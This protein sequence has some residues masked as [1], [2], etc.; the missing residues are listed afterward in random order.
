ML[1]GRRRVLASPS[2]QNYCRHVR[3][4]SQFK[5]DTAWVKVLEF[6]LGMEVT[7]TSKRPF[8]FAKKRRPTWHRGSTEP[9]RTGSMHVT[10][11]RC[12]CLPESPSRDGDRRLGVIYRLIGSHSPGLIIIQAPN[13][14]FKN[15]GE[16]LGHLRV[17][18]M[19]RT[20]EGPTAHRHPSSPRLRRHARATGIPA[21]RS[22]ASPRNTRARPRPWGSAATVR[23]EI[24]GRARARARGGADKIWWGRGGA[25]PARVAAPMVVKPRSGWLGV[26]P[27]W[28]C[29]RERPAP[30]HV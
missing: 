28:R 29:A 21:S 16:R 20:S 3:R 30:P 14:Q 18:L 11:H 2:L 12:P 23:F 9:R 25:G 17:T 10:R 5:I 8:C 24:R 19:T 13:F 27:V 7:R 6:K 22:P 15:Q 1:V 26:G 4:D